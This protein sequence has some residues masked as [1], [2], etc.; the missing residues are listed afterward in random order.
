MIKPPQLNNKKGYVITLTNKSKEIRPEQ[1][2]MEWCIQTFYNF[3][4][5]GG[6]R[7]AMNVSMA[8]TGA[9]SSILY[10]VFKFIALN[11]HTFSLFMTSENRKGVF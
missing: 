3:S 11:K 4:V 8:S 6:G 10:H 7:Q 9:G 1:A 5:T 2:Q